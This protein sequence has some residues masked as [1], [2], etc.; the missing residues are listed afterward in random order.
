MKL[1]LILLAGIST[2][3]GDLIF[4]SNDI[5][6]QNLEILSAKYAQI[7]VLDDNGAYLVPSEC[8]SERYFGGAS[9]GVLNL[10]KGPMRTETVL[11]TQE[12]FEAKEAKQI[13]KKIELDKTFAIAEGKI[14]KDFLE[15]K[16]GRGFG[17]ASEVPLVIRNEIQTSTPNVAVKALAKQSQR[18]SCQILSDGSGYKIDALNNGRLYINGKITPMHNDTVSFQ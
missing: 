4:L 13:V 1:L 10:V 9:E 7:L 8:K 17:G 18:P 3:A 16:E 15:D 6:A 12:V 14:S 2:Y 5:T 11:N